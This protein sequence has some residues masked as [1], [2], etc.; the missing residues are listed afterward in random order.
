MMDKFL[1][2]SFW[3]DTYPSPFSPVIF[4]ICLGLFA[5]GLALAIV[6]LVLQKKFR[7]DKITFTVYEKLKNFGF[8]FG[9]VGLIL[10]FFKQQQAIYLGMRIWLALWLLASLLWLGLVLKYL[11]FKAPALRLEKKKKEELR[12][13]LP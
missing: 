4:W 1:Q 5:F 2:L 11:L 12:K 7:A 10:T 8:G 6:S 3:F 9:S 13:Y